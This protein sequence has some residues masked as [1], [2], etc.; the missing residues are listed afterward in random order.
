MILF[1]DGDIVAYRSASACETPIHWGDGLW[2]LHAREDAVMHH[3]DVFMQD[4]Q[5]QSGLKDVWTA[6]SSKNNFRKEVSSSYKANRKNIR[7]PMLLNFAKDYLFQHW[8]GKMKDKLEA[9]DVLG[10]YG[11]ADMDIVIWSP[12]KDLLTVPSKH[13]IN[14]EIVTITQEEADKNFYIQALAGDMTD[15]YSGCPKVGK[16]TAEKILA[17][18]PYWE[19]VVTAYE[20][21]GL[22]EEVALENARLARILRQGEYIERADGTGEVNLW[23]PMQQA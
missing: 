1:V 17:E 8:G 15:G 10:L 19:K 11:T 12:D 14:G 2:T 16:K 18:P 5:K 21:A 22:S 13:F 3:M 20:K 9:D 7:K 6:I 4:L 23:T